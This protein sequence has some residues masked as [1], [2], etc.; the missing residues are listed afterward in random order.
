MIAADETPMEMALRVI[1]NMKT[2]HLAVANDCAD[3]GKPEL[4][5]HDG[6]TSEMKILQ[7]EFN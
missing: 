3:A 5:K 2:D 1:D 6:G 7:R 4:A